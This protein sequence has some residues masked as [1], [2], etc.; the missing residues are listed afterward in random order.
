MVN[1]REKKMFVHFTKTVYIIGN[2][3][4]LR[5]IIYFKTVR[6]NGWTKL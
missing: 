1:N 3:D 6:V 2:G 5:E 4:D